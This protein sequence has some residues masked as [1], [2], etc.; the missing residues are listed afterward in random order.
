MF[1]DVFMIKWCPGIVFCSFKPDKWELFL[2][3]SKMKKEASTFHNFTW[4]FILIQQI[5]M[6]NTFNQ[7]TSEQTTHFFV[8]ASFK[9]IC[10]PT[11]LHG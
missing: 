5:I 3:F 4:K 6:V 8:V 1:V 10:G 11:L 7:A 2:M 9:S